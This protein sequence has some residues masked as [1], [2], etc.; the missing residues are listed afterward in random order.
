MAALIHTNPH[1]PEIFRTNIVLGNSKEF[2][3]TFKCPAGSKMNPTDKCSV[4]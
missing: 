3:E 4:W 2:S 1:P